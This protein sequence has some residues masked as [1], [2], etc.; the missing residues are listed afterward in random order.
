MRILGAGVL[1]AYIKHKPRTRKHVLAFRSLVSASSWRQLKDVEVQFGQVATFHPPDGLAF[2]F[3][4]EDL[5]I[6]MRVDFDLGLV[7]VVM[8]IAKH[9]REKN[10]N[11]AIRPIRNEADYQAALAQI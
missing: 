7:L 3:A 9:D 6:D 4:E 5:R 8:P 2:E 10:M 1:T 11:D